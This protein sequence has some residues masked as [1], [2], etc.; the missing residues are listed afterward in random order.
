MKY[1]DQ[2][3]NLVNKYYGYVYVTIDLKYNKVYVGKKKGKPEKTKYYFGSG[4]IIT[5]IKK[6]R[7][8]YF[9]KKII[10]GVCYDLIE[11]EECEYQ[12][13]CHFDVWN[14]LYGYNIIERDTEGDSMT[15]NPNIIEIKKKI[16]IGNTGKIRSEELKKQISDKLIGRPSTRKGKKL[17]EEIKEKMSFAKRGEK[18][19]FF[20][21]HHTKE[22]RKLISESKIGKPHPLKGKKRNKKIIIDIQKLLELKSR[23]YFLNDLAKEFNCCKNTIVRRLK[24][25]ADVD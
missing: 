10:L 18:N 19:Y 5:N 15:N 20:G 21:K 8:T 24:E 7:G 2:N 9:L 11:L 13:K 6:S 17:S 14:R 22:T 25:I 4:T 3:G 1:L 16:S 12:C 23:G